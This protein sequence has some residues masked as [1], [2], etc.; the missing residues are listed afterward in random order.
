MEFRK[1]ITIIIPPIIMNKELYNKNS[2]FNVKKYIPKLF[3]HFTLAAQERFNNIYA[4]DHNYIKSLPVSYK[5]LMNTSLN[6]FKTISKNFS[7]KNVIEGIS[8]LLYILYIYSLDI[9]GLLILI[10]SMATARL[11]SI[12]ISKLNANL[13]SSKYTSTFFKT[14]YSYIQILDYFFNKY[15]TIKSLW[16]L[17]SLIYFLFHLSYS[18]ISI[19]LASIIILIYINYINK[20]FKDNYPLLHIFLNF[21]FISIIISCII[22]QYIV[23][24]G[25]SNNGSG[26]PHSGG[27]GGGN[28]EPP[29]PPKPSMSEV[30]EWLKKKRES[31]RDK[32][33]ASRKEYVDYIN[34]RS[35][36]LGGHIYKKGQFNRSITEKNRPND[37]SDNYSTFGSRDNCL[38]KY[39]EWPFKRM[40]N[41]NTAL[42]E[43]ECIQQTKLMKN[44]LANWEKADKLYSKKFN[45]KY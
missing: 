16:S 31:S 35:E 6:F 44:L 20:N 17:I 41:S 3:R 10:N 8:L 40:N 33:F 9:N 24:V 29:K 39:Y 25:S 13:N 15:L 14:L 27:Y 23:Y 2:N 4:Y 26:N 21:F 22:N 11:I 5:H 1:P 45:K 37:Y 28:P 32:R 12:L 30:K 43:T 38:N 34:D 42:F 18:A 19:V 7:F 36:R